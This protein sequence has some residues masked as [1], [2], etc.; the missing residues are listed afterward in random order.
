M[1]RERVSFVE[2]DGPDGISSS[3]IRDRL[4]AGRSVRH[5]VHPRVLDYIVMNDLYGWEMPL[6]E[7]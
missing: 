7:G 3:L 1:K 4:E 2:V 6:G 5:L